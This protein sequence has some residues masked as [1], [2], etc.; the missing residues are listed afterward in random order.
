MQKTLGYDLF[1]KPEPIIIALSGKKG[2]GKNT[3]SSFINDYFSGYWYKG[4]R[5]GIPFCI[6][7]AFADLIK[8]FCID[9]LGLEHK[10]CHGSDEE[11]NTLTKYEWEDT[12]QFHLGWDGPKYM[13][14]REVMQMFGTESVRAWFGNVWAEATLRKIKNTYPTCLLPALAI[15]TDNRFP[16][17]DETIPGHPRGYIIRLTRDPFE[18]DN[19]E[20]EIALDD[21]DWDHERCYVL[22]NGAL[23]KEEQI[24]TIKPILDEIFTQ[25]LNNG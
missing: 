15:V 9:V 23:S 13:S 5:N 17:E 14:G 1:A 20:S 8:E 24:E 7:I 12:P 19:H 2:S 10:Q 22:D 11:K 25:E 18:S 6:E 21:Y 3:L 4:S 16:S